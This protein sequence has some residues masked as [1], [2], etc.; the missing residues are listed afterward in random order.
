MCTLLWYLAL[1]RDSFYERLNRH[2]RVFIIVSIPAFS[3]TMITWFDPFIECNDLSLIISHIWDFPCLTLID[4]WPIVIL[5][6]N[7]IT[8][9]FLHSI[10]KQKRINWSLMSWLLNLSSLNAW[11]LFKL[12]IFMISI[13]M[14]AILSLNLSIS[15]I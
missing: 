10:Q 7:K 8:I 4:L 13:W 1:K 14:Y 12:I 11:L 2:A 15:L 5:K 9:I 6:S 3:L